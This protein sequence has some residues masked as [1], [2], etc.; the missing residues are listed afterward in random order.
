MKP[1]LAMMGLALL[2]ATGCR[3]A[4]R[5]DLSGQW[6]QEIFQAE[7]DFARM[8]LE[9]GIE[10]AFLAF[11]AED[12]V[13]MRNNQL[14]RGRKEIREWFSSRPSS[15]PSKVKLAW[16]PDFVEVS[17][18]GDLG[19]TYGPYSLTVTDSTGASETQTGVF[20]T[21]WKRQAD[22]SWKFVWD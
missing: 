1:Y 17:A 8:A 12:A 6:K 13:L 5:E 21:V 7:A 11:A 16:E 22:G 14:V 19:Y 2:L 4:A 3:Q 20:H 9:E 18:S 15:D 10:P